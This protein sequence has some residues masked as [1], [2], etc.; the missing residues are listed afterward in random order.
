MGKQHCGLGGVNIF[1]MVETIMRIRNS[2]TTHA[3]GLNRYDNNIHT[4][5]GLNRGL[6]N[7]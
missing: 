6:I 5:H 7:R 1:K 3:N 2:P 4:T